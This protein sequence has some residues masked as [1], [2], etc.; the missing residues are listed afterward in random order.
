MI[1]VL[2]CQRHV[3][4]ERPAR[5]TKTLGRLP[6]QCLCRMVSRDSHHCAHGN[7]EGRQWHWESW[8][9]WVTIRKVYSFP[10]RQA[11]RVL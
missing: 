8:C 10:A 4:Q 6:S 2:V 5:D 9:Q 7:L 1:G 11:V 3:H